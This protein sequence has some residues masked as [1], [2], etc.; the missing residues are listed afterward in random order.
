M[1]GTWR[2]V[3]SVATLVLVVPAY[4]RAQAIL[5]EKGEGSVSMLFT[6]SLATKHYLPTT[7]FDRG[8]ID[9]NSLLVDFTF[10]L[11]DRVAVSVS[12]PFVATRYR[13]GSPHLLENGQRALLDDGSWHV[14]PQDLRFGVRY[15]LIQR[16]VVITPFVGTVT[17]SHRYDFFAHA[18]PGRATKEILAGVSAARVF[19]GSG[20][21][22]QGR[23]A[24]GVG[25]RILGSRPRHSEGQ[26][27]IG[28]FLT[29]SVRLVGI[30]S[31]RYGHTGIDITTSAR[32]TLPWEQY[33]NHDRIA[34]EHA[35]NT[36]G[37]VSLTLSDSIDVFA[38]VLTTVAA[39]NS[40][41]MKY[42]L[43][44]GVSW[45]F[46][47]PSEVQAAGNR[48]TPLARCVCQKAVK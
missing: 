46:R 47:Q 1:S 15:N 30:A 44:A 18:S 38:S 39:R 21:F 35:L 31:G 40:H 17:P 27:E 14:T 25:E 16:G 3:L 24:L 13:G 26:V 42:S 41:G 36:G 9:A 48:A 37:G 22:V 19:T 32:S 28:Y 2:T 33:Y 6:N 34:R 29:D 4:S 43:T 45:T 7:A 20:I 8:H 10:G 11:S 12:L 23:Y 5:P